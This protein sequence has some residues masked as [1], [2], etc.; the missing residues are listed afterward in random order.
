MRT[1]DL[2][3]MALA[4]LWQQKT[5]TALTTLGVTLGA[6]MLTFSLS[7]GQ[8]VQDTLNRQFRAHDDLRRIQVYGGRGGKDYDE[9]GIP[10]ESIEVKGVHY[11]VIGILR[12]KGFRARVPVGIG[13]QSGP[14]YAAGRTADGSTQSGKRT[15]Q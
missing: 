13:Q 5:R 3:R 2:L 10:A 11:R 1:A 15:I 9:S 6:C 12:A 8:G 14:T 7:I 4:A